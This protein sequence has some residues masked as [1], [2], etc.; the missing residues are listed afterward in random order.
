MLKFIDAL[1]LKQPALVGHDW[2]AR[3]VAIACRLRP[4]FASHLVMMSVSYGT[5]DPSQQLSLQ[6]ARNYRYHWYVATPRG[7][8]SVR[9]D[10]RN[11]SRAM[12]DTWPPQGW[13]RMEEFEATAK[14]F[15]NADWANVTLH[16]YR[17]RWGMRQV[18]HTMQTRNFNSTRRPSWPSPRCCCMVLPMESIIQTP[19]WARKLFSAAPISACCWWA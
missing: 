13:Y 19:A 12:W 1:G 6:Q 9:D 8:R 7:E 18:T 14:A 10:G 5:N 16:C 11:F 15:E 17:H 3:A 4:G 2:G